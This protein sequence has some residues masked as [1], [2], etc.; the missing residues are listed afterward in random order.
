[1][2][3]LHSISQQYWA[4]FCL[5]KAVVSGRSVKCRYRPQLR[6]CDRIATM[7]TIFRLRVISSSKLTAC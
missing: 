6:Q 4:F 2:Q 3:S 7:Q 1:M 5:L